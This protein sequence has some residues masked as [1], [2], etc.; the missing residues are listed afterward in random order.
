MINVIRLLKIQSAKDILHCF[1]EHVTQGVRM[2][3]DNTYH[4]IFLRL[5]AVISCSRSSS[6][7]FITVAVNVNNAMNEMK[8]QSIASLL[9]SSL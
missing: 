5:L 3:W 4:L 7:Q 1:D 9:S 2:L 6:L 8:W